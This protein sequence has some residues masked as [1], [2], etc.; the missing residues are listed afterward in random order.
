MATDVEKWVLGEDAAWASKDAEKVLPFY[1]DDCLYEDLAIGKVCHGKEEIREFIKS[2]FA[3]FPDFKIEIKSFFFSADRVCIES[4]LSGTNT[5][6]VP[7]FPPPTGKAFSVRGA[8]ICELQGD[9]ASRVTDY[10]NLATIMQQLGHLP[11][12]G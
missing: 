3:S 4:I 12:P 11:S 2:A 6:S 7:G 8:H 10:Y 1:A 9:K 5:E